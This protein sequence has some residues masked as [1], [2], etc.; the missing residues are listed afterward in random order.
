MSLSHSVREN[1]RRCSDRM[2]LLRLFQKPFFGIISLFFLVAFATSLVCISAVDSQLSKEYTENS[3]GL[4]RSIADSS[5]DIL[6]NR[7]LSTLQALI[8]KSLDIQGIS[9]IYITN[10]NREI[11]AH[12]F[13][14]FVPDEV[15]QGI[16]E[17]FQKDPSSPVHRP[18]N[19]SGIGDF[20][21]VSF[22]ILRS[23]A[24]RV[25][26]LMDQDNISLKI[27][28]AIGQQVIWMA[29]ILTVGFFL[30]LILVNLTY[31]P[32]RETLNYATGLARG[33]SVDDPKIQTL[34]ERK[35]E[36]GD[37]AR[38]FQYFA[39]VRDPD[40]TGKLPVKKEE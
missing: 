4:A 39:S 11:L 36:T 35:D 32:I 16:E 17:L 37:L 9:Y 22:P 28:N 3:E 8:D 27:Q 30:V 7:D 15:L 38:L 23:E 33:E 29:I 25:Q 19:L 14:P 21:E 18:L 24:G 31:N 20:L 13:V 2:R 34:L 40:K 1:G 6:L 10:E 26:I 12:T 5:V